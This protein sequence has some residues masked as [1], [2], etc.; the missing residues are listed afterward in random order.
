MEGAAFSRP[1]ERSDCCLQLPQGG[2]GQGSSKN[3]R[4]DRHGLCKGGF[5]LGMGGNASQ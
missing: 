5:S 2:S 1:E 4:G 3:T